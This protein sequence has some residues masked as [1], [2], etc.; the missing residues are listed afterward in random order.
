KSSTV[1]VSLK[2]DPTGIVV[3][4]LPLVSVVP[5]VMLTLGGVGFSTLMMAL[6][7]LGVTAPSPFTSS[8]GDD[9]SVTKVDDDDTLA[10]FKNGPDELAVL[11]ETECEPFAF[12]SL[13][14]IRASSD[15]T[16]PSLFTSGWFSRF[17]MLMPS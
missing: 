16:C 15:D 10:A 3:I 6:T 13:M 12:R 5:R 2:S 17:R 11:E 9:V 14:T 1:A 8:K 4:T 7:S